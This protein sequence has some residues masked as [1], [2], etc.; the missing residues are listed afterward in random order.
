[1][2]E[3][4]AI[5]TGRYSSR[6]RCRPGCAGQVITA[7]WQCRRTNFPIKVL[8]RKR[9][10]GLTW[11]AVT[12]GKMLAV[13]YEPECRPDLLVLGKA[14]SGGFECL[15]LSSTASCSAPSLPPDLRVSVVLVVTACRWCSVLPVSAVLC[16]NHIMDVIDPGS[17]GSTS[18]HR[19]SVDVIPAAPSHCCPFAATAA[20]LT[21]SPFDQQLWRQSDVLRRRDGG[22]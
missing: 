16:D 7:W 21:C 4:C 1:M 17:H 2:C 5:S 13:D 11:S 18:A 6:M 10:V 19:N 3:R 15:A 12:T 9:E 22:A 8:R 14:L 20:P